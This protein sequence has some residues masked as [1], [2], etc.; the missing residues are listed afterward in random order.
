MLVVC[1]GCFGPSDAE[2]VIFHIAS[3]ADLNTGQASR[4]Y[5]CA[6]LQSE[7]FIHC[8]KA[9]QLPG[10]VER[11]YQ[12]VA[13]IMVLSID[14]DKLQAELVYENTVGGEEL[15]PHVYGEINMDAVV[16]VAP[17]AEHLARAP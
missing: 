1:C 17:L 13:G 11:Y 10:V 16:K 7:G 3:Q 6:S 15:F 5:R 9:E 8:C 4:C 2:S 12:G 14:P